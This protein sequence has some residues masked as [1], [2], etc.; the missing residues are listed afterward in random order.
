[1]S[2][3]NHMDSC[4]DDHP[5][6]ECGVV[7]IYL[8]NTGG[9]EAAQ[10]TFYALFAL[11]HRGQESAGIAA[12]DGRTLRNFT[13]MGLVSNAFRQEDIERLPGHV[14][15]GHTRYS[16]MGS[17][18]ALNAQPIVS[19]GPELEI[20]L[21]H[22]GNIINAVELR[23]GLREKG[24]SCVT[25]TDTE[26]IA[27][28]IT[29]SSGSTWEERSVQLMR[30]VQGA[31]SLVLTTK[32]TLVAIRDPLGIRPLALGR[33]GGGWII[34][35][36]SVA[37]DHVGAQFM[38]E[39]APGETIV[40]GRD[41]LT[42]IPGS[43]DSGNKAHCVFE[44]IYFARPDSILDGVLV[45]KS[46]LNMGATLAAEHPVEA[47]L[48]IP[49]PDSANSAAIGYSQASGIPYGYGLIKNR[50]VGRTFI[51]PD[52][53]FRE[54][55]VRNKYNPLP[56]V[57]NGKRIVVVDDS[58]VRGT[59]TPHVIA[60]LRRAGAAEIHMRVCAPPIRHPCHFG[61]DM[62]SKGEFLASD[63]TIEEVCQ[64]IGADSLGY[65]SVPG[66][67]NSVNGDSSSNGFCNACFTGNYPIPVQLQLDKLT[68][69]RPIVPPSQ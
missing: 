64:I 61:V 1:L 31:Y 57:L 62:A 60:L 22:N 39:V 66:L 25:T 46:R 14:A 24:V 11:Q 15:I 26:I 27:H 40:I 34:A 65:L 37:M 55:G 30:A 41:G 9:T 21:G 44:H 23:E 50:Y 47:D 35:S 51:N 36:E 59:T 6:D 20:A 43:V 52:Q 7:G 49:I 56:E 4:R 16:T 63:R 69:E 54:L 17:S 33:Y 67:H 19:Q 53:H 12:G 5:R 68:L 29:W 28:L 48:V 2:S 13:N 38:R 32:D 8:P 10:A 18:Q 3:V 45:H 42:S 58:I